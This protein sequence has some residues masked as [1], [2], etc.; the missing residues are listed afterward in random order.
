MTMQRA[1]IS[2]LNCNAVAGVSTDG[3]PPGRR[4]TRA[5]TLVELL[6]VIAILA[7]LIAL[8]LP[9]LTRA[10]EQ[11]RL[12]KCKANIRQVLAAHA[13]YAV[14]YKDAKPPLVFQYPPPQWEISGMEPT[15]EPLGFMSP[16]TRYYIQNVGHGLLI[17]GRLRTLN[18]LLC[19]A[20]EMVKDNARDLAMWG[21]GVTSFMAGS[22]YIYFYRGG[23]AEV[24]GKF[25]DDE[26]TKKNRARGFCAGVT[27]TRAM[28]QKQFALMIDTCIQGEATVITGDG[29]FGPRDWVA[30]ERLGRIN[31]GFVDGSVKDVRAK[32]VM[33]KHPF[34]LDEQFK[35]FEEA[36]RQY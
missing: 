1:D 10:T 35:W 18:T 21:D 7:L 32:D 36:C 19:P 30:H 17:P 11:A 9:A 28:R 29:D 27:Y 8:L 24:A 6:A 31:I 22:S 15:L 16:N 4:L 26:A 3:F 13:S 5:F 14:D 33:L 2:V 12:V 23:P 25:D 34:G 20:S